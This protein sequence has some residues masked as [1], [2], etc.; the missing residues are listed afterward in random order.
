MSIP[1]YPWSDW[2]SENVQL[3]DNLLQFLDLANYRTGSAHFRGQIVFDF[4]LLLF[5]ASQVIILA[6]FFGI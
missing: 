4:F 2:L 5:V 3:N 1:E 6:L